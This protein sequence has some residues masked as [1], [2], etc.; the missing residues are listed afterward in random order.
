MYNTEGPEI[1]R[2]YTFKDNSEKVDFSDVLDSFYN[3]VDHI[4]YSGSVQNFTILCSSVPFCML[5]NLSGRF[6]IPMRKDRFLTGLEENMLSEDMLQE[7]RGTYCTYTDVSLAS[8]VLLL[9]L[10]SLLQL[11]V[12]H[13]LMDLVEQRDMTSI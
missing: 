3:N 5:S 2:L 13:V 4:L 9:V 6:I 10:L 7:K 11:K 1:S 12:S 8:Y